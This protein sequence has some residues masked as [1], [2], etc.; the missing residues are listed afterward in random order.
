DAVPIRHIKDILDEVKQK[1]AEETKDE[2]ED[3]T[4]DEYDLGPAMFPWEK[5]GED[6]SEE[7]K[8]PIDLEELDR[9]ARELAAS[10]TFDDLPE[11]LKRAFRE[12]FDLE[13]NEE[14]TT[15]QDP[16]QNNPGETDETEE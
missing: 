1:K 5:S 4:D 13:Q 12:L 16:S 15:P 14:D 3:T 10:A 6:A 8:D 9:H 2:E 11:E 7:E